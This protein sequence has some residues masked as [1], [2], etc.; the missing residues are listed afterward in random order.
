[1]AAQVR[2][3]HSV[4]TLPS[5]HDSLIRKALGTGF[6]DLQMA[7][8]WVD[9]EPGVAVT[10]RCAVI[11]AGL[12]V[13][14]EGKGVGVV[15][16]LFAGLLSRYAGEYQSLRTIQ[17]AGFAV[18]AALDTKQAKSGVDAMGTVT[19]DVMNSYG[20]RFTFTDSSRSL[21]ASIARVVVASVQ[22]FINAERAFI[23]LTKAQKDAVARGRD[24]LATRYTAELA[25][26]V[27][28]TS[29]ADV[30]ERLRGGSSS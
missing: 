3:R 12:R 8:L 4:T 6:L 21:T 29:Y 20:R 22:F 15:D 10:V 25:E 9:E 16:A 14:I 2:Y 11:E 24:D 27:E 18:S 30:I 23:T 28:C 5:E 13:E 1:L 26:V 17:L 7:R 19:L